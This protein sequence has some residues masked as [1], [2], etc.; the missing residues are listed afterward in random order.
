[1]STRK[2]HQ[3]DVSKHAVAEVKTVLR[4]SLNAE[5]PM[6]DKVSAQTY[7]ILAHFARIVLMRTWEALEESVG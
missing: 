5:E 2:V 7:Q 4:I 6:L 3:N 1:V